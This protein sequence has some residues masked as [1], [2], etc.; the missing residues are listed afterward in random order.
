VARSG[1]VQQDTRVGATHWIEVPLRVN[2]AIDQIL[3]VDVSAAF[4]LAHGSPLDP[5]YIGQ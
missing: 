5:N 1:G 2:V 3:L 4:G